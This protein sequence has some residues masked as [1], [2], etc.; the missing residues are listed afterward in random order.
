MPEPSVAA[1][2]TPVTPVVIAQHVVDGVVPDDV[3]CA[4]ALSFEQVVLQDLLGPQLVAAMDQRHVR[5]DVGEVQ[6]FLDRGV[7]AADDR[8]TLAAEEEA[9][10]G[11]A[12]RDAAAA[13][14]LLGREARGSARSRR[15]R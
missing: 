5:G 10:A 8:D 11:R 15:S 4:R 3:D 12:G 6:R 9:V 1:M 13:E 14:C 2:R 7:A